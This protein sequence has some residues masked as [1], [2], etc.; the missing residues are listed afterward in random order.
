MAPTDPAGSGPAPRPPAVLAQA[1]AGTVDDRSPRLP[2]RH[3]HA[4]PQAQIHQSGAPPA[5]PFDQQSRSYRRI[6]PGSP[7]VDVIQRA[8]KPRACAAGQRIPT[9]VLQL[10]GR[11][12]RSQPPGQTS[13]GARSETKTPTGAPSHG[14]RPGAAVTSML[15]H[16]VSC[17]SARPLLASCT[18]SS[19]SAMRSVPCSMTPAMTVPPPVIRKAVSTLKRNGSWAMALAA[20]SEPVQGLVHG[21][22]DP[23]GGKFADRR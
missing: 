14:S 3:L 2:Q 20:G 23:P 9:G 10:P 5:T 19:S 8:R 7:S 12:C 13:S 18:S 21:E 17:V 11:R 1:P 22:G 4:A 6:R 16:R 15:M